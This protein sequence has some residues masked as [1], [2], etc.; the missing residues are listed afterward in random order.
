MVKTNLK[1]VSISAIIISFVGCSKD[2][3]RSMVIGTYV[4]N[5]N[6]GIDTLVIKADGT[7]RYFFK[8]K[9][10]KVF[11]NSNKW[12]FEYFDG[13]PIISFED[14]IFVHD[15]EKRELIKGILEKEGIKTKSDGKGFWG[16]YPKT[17]LFGKIRLSIDPDLNYYYEKIEE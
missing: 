12:V 5:H 17:S 14:F 2:V 7:Y 10:G 13:N 1:A 8:D 3:D 4:A 15:E 6:L 16:V 9:N 11:T